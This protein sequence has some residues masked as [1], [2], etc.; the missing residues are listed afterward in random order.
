MVIATNELIKTLKK[1][2]S[3]KKGENF[4]YF[5]DKMD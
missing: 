1:E 5:S 2:M 4:M 3:L